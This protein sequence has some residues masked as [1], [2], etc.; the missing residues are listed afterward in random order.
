MLSSI[1]KL[2]ELTM[3]VEK[4]PVLKVLAKNV[5]FQKKKK[6]KHLQTMH[7]LWLGFKSYFL[8]MKSQYQIHFKFR[9]CNYRY[10]Y[11]FF[12]FY[13]FKKIIFIW[14]ERLLALQVSSLCIGP[15]SDR[16]RQQA[17]GGRTISWSA[18]KGPFQCRPLRCRE[19]TLSWI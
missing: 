7:F 15:Q 13:F 4:Q 18:T 16:Q 14:I 2:L 17:R 8:F 5:I 11:S 12:Y 6:K 9:T 1:K 19:R 10:I 3:L